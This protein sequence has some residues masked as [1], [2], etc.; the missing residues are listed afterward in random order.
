VFPSRCISVHCTLVFD[1]GKKREVMKEN[2]MRSP[3]YGLVEGSLPLSRVFRVHD[4]DKQLLRWMATELP[5]LIFYSISPFCF[6]C[7]LS[8]F[9]F[10]VFSSACLLAVRVTCPLGL[11]FFL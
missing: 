7:G 5:H 10:C 3:G 4:R 8:V 11:S 2:E 1:V 9:F 6:P